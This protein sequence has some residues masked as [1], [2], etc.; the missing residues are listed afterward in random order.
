M[1]QAHYDLSVGIP[2]TRVCWLCFVRSRRVVLRALST[3]VVVGTILTIIN[4]GDH[5]LR[6]EFAVPMMLKI[7]LTY[8]VPYLVTVWGTLAGRR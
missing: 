5:I 1:R 2:I 4:Q 3:S 8:L 7:P 6:A